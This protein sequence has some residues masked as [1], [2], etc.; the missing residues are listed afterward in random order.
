MP[1]CDNLLRT[2]A[3]SNPS[4]E[5]AKRIAQA[6][7]AELG[8]KC[9]ERRLGRTGKRLIVRRKPRESGE[10]LTLREVAGS[11]LLEVA[12][13]R[14]KAGE[15]GVEDLQVLL[16][17]R[18]ADA[19]A[20]VPGQS[21]QVELDNVEGGDHR[22]RLGHAFWRTGRRRCQRAEEAMLLVVE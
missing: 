6:V 14:R 21:G 7:A 16:N 1:V 4:R 19:E 11:V 15:V 17:A 8:K 3:R 12:F 22:L 9:G 20:H 13:G 2:P 18:R 10:Q 5:T